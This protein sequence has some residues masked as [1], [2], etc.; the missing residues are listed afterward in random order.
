MRIH[1][2]DTEAGTAIIELDR[3]AIGRIS[4]LMHDAKCTGPVRAHF[5]LLYEI[6]SH[7]AFDSFSLTMGNNIL[8]GKL[9]GGAEEK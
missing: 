5:Y 7:K 8:T 6:L 3:A 2:I 4:N 1:K 9:K